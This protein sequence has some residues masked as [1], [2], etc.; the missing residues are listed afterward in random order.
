[1]ETWRD[2]G[3]EQFSD[4]TQIP[5]EDTGRIQV[6]R[7]S[8]SGSRVRNFILWS[9]KKWKSKG[10]V[11]LNKIVHVE[12]CC[13]VNLL[14]DWLIAELVRDSNLSIVTEHHTLPGL[15]EICRST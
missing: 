6:V 2:W 10:Q 3:P 9:V 1:M 14:L 15:E 7:P 12:Y 8:F 5:F 4:I 13:Y 11:N